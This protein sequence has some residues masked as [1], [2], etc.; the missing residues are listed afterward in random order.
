ML[1]TCQARASTTGADTYCV[2]VQFFPDVSVS[3]TC[4]AFPS[5]LSCEVLAR[6]LCGLPEGHLRDQWKLH[7][8]VK[9]T[10][11]PA[12]Y[13]LAALDK[14][15]WLDVGNISLSLNMVQLWTKLDVA[16]VSLAGAHL[17]AVVS[18]CVRMLD[19]MRVYTLFS[20]RS[21]VA[22]LWIGPR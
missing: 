14:P 16:G 18:P 20:L 3:W 9:V 4:G 8:T 22:C 6:L 10:D 5:L 21:G 2:I 12:A 15:F 19:L 7:H 13:F 17:M 11:T 1:C